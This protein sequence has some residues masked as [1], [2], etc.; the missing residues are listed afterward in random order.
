MAR[1]GS[2][3]P[4]GEDWVGKVISR[5]GKAAK[6]KVAEGNRKGKPHG[7]YASAHDLRWSFATRWVQKMMR[8]KSIQTTLDYYAEIQSEAVEDELRRLFEAVLGSMGR[9]KR[10]QI[11][12][13][14]PTNSLAAS[15]I[16]GESKL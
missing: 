7:K 14:P 9:V 11:G 5:I 15:T 16:L 8:H 10:H 4:M 2:D 13:G 6:V 3:T 1:N 12:R